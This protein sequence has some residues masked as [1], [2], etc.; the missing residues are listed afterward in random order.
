MKHL[1]LAQARAHRG[2]YVASVLAVFVAVAFVVTT[3]VL[4]DTV[5]AS[6]SKST[7]ARYEGV[8][9]VALPADSTVAP[10][11]VLT[12]VATTPG[13]EAAALDVSG[14]VR[15][16]GA[17]GSSSNGTATS[18]APEGALR[19]Q[20]L[21]D[22]R[23]PSNP[24]EVAVGSS[25]GRAIGD[26]ITVAG[27]TGSVPPT[28]VEVV[29]VVDL[30]GSPLALS[31][32][33]V[34]GDAAQ[35]RSWSGDTT[36]WE[37]RAVGDADAVRAA[38]APVPGVDVVPG[39]DRATAVA[40]DYVGDVALLRNVLLCFAAISV[41][42]AGLVIAN[43]FSVLL[44]ARTRELALMRCVGV[45]STQVRRSVRGEAFV[46][47]L[48]AAVLGVLGG[49]G[50][51]A[52]VVSAAR[53]VD[54]PIPLTSVSV[55]ATTVIAGLIVG[56]GMTVVAANG[57]A[58][59]ATRVRALAA[60]QPLETRPE[61][62][63]DSW[64]RRI[65]AAL[66]IVGGTAL[67]GLG[68]V[69]ANV[70]VACPGGLLLFVG[71]VLASRRLVP[72]AVGAVG[73]VLARAGGP[74]AVLA[75]G[76]ARRNPRRTA[77]TA[78][79]LFIGVTLTSTLVVGIGTLEAGA[80]DVIDEQ[81]PVD[82]AVTAP[83]RD[84]LAPE[85]TER[86]TAVDRVSSGAE[87]AAVDL[88]IGGTEASVLGVDPAAMASTVRTDVRLPEAGTIVLERSLARSVGVDDGAV[89][90]VGGPVGTRELTVATTEPGMPDMIEWSDLTAVAGPV[91]ADTVWL[92]LDRGMSDEDLVAV[93][94]DLSRVAAA[95][96]PGSEVVG[97]VQMRQMLE[98]ILDTMLLIV[99]GLL[100]VAVV[101]AL[102]GV[103][104][105]M[106]LSVLERRRET[107]ML[108]SVGLS[109]A[110]VRSLL[111]REASII[112]GVASLLGVVLG[113]LLGAAGTASVIGPGHIAPGSVPWWQL[114]AIV[115]V[116]GVAGVVASLVPA[117]RAS[118]VSPVAAMA[119]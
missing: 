75:A 83:E 119:G 29:G 42:V 65:C 97:A 86:L 6:V 4:G 58:R 16:I 19:W 74:L 69:V 59:A 73:D 46:V 79:A 91:T 108:R 84:G 11:E 55:T 48:V 56:T 114:A 47:G 32:G 12:L 26:E 76:N 106:A 111:V 64:V 30:D 43:T 5:S 118:R 8:A 7:A 93:S 100:S 35:V 80:P 45:T 20:Q 63:R 96:V 18:I 71:V 25:S 52:A 53:A 41:V 98:K 101:I 44:A 110:G 10:D 66:A 1:V 102:I 39:A 113:L 61:P 60:L 21:G 81:F 37:V 68:V 38:L 117:Q 51:A 103:G 24:A 3:L 78:T 57:A 107:A 34:F 116:G 9:A 14:P 13:V 89:I 72:A 2:R 28:T 40:D 99:G 22:G 67:L 90:T 77:S 17:D 62:V 82:M 27:P 115:L 54:A 87:L 85:V 31:P 105:T 70:L 36:D 104:N 92:K 33:P 50:L 15:L 88:T 49:S 94:D 112:A 95:E 23:W 109:R